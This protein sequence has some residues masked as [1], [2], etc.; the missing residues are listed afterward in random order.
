MNCGTEDYPLGFL[1]SIIGDACASHDQCFA[2]G[3]ASFTQ[4]NLW[5]GLEVGAISFL[6]F[7]GLAFFLTQT[8]GRK[9]YGKDDNSKK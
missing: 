3:V 9:Y 8:F 5:F 2:D 7:G 6:L 1:D 4:C